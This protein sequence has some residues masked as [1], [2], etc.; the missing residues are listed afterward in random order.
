[1]EYVNMNFTDFIKKVED[2][3]MS[4]QP[5]KVRAVNRW[6]Y[7]QTL[8]NVLWDVWPEK[9]NEIK[10]SDLDCFYT[11]QHVNLT[12]AKLEK[13][14]HDD[15]EEIIG[16]VDAIIEIVENKPHKIERMF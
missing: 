10:D 5:P 12:I 2:T 14:W 3:F 1:M 7:G 15:I 13:E 6:R 8:M 9:Y 4:N 16:C 11:N